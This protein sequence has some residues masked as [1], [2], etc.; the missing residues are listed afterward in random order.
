MYGW[1][2]VLWHVLWIGLFSFHHTRHDLPLQF[3]FIASG[4]MNWIMIDFAMKAAEDEKFLA[5]KCGITM[6]ADAAE[7]SWVVV[8]SAELSCQ[9]RQ[10]KWVKM[11]WILFYTGKHNA[12]L[13]VSVLS[14]QGWLR[15]LLRFDFIEARWSEQCW[16][17]I[18]SLCEPG[19]TGNRPLEDIMWS[20]INVT[21]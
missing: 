9:S 21:E 18:R 20:S 12:V 17:M 11:S 16:S 6:T 3:P 10:G 5:R 14:V 7:F 8:K 1:D 15:K 2:W 19:N 4:S 13:R